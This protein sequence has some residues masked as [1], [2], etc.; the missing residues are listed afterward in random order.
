MYH[1]IDLNFQSCDRTIASFLIET[2]ESPVLIESGPYSTFSTLEKGL[3]QHGYKPED[4]GHLLLT[5]IHFDHAGAAWALAESGAKVYVHPFGYKHLNHPEKLVSSAKMLYKDDMDKLFGKMEPI[6]TSSLKKVEDKENITVGGET[7]R[8]LHTP[9]HAKHHI[10]WQWKD[11]IF[12]GDVGGVKIGKGPVVP[13]CPPPDIDLTDWINSIEKIVSEHANQWVLTHF[14]K[15]TNIRSHADSL[16]YM[17]NDW[18]LWIKNKW[19]KGLSNE[20]ITPLFIEYTTHQLKKHGLSELEL[21]QYE[22]AN[23]SWMSV[24]GLTRY[25]KKQAEL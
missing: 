8:A 21:K 4:I 11:I 15:I 1:I 25:W 14:G 20:E 17:L 16:K 12:T 5:H 13:P 22:L 2:E 3:K 18:S 23:Q 7:F 19:E 10:A 6:K 9:G 24:T